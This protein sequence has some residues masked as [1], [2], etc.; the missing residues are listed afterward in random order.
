MSMRNKRGKLAALLAAAMMVFTG[1]V[2]SGVGV[3]TLEMTPEPWKSL[4]GSTR[5]TT[6]P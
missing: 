6:N 1:C 4:L 2:R 5:N 3:T